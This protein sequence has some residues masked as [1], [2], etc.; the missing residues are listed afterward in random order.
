MTDVRRQN[1]EASRARLMRKARARMKEAG[2]RTGG[3]SIAHN[4]GEPRPA[5]ADNPASPIQ[6]MRD[7]SNDEADAMGGQGGQECRPEGIWASAP[8]DEGAP[9]GDGH[10]M[11]ASHGKGQIDAGDDSGSPDTESAGRDG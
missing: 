6:I 11:R 1:F 7:T 5:G 2:I 4:L 9:D 3:S 10:P 8:S